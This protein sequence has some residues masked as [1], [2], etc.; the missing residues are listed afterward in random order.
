MANEAILCELDSARNA[1]E[2]TVSNGTAISKN[3]IL[4]LADP[5]TASASTGTGDIFGG[6]MAADKI[7]SDGATKASA[8]LEGKWKLVCNS[9]VAISTG[10]KVTS[11]GANLIRVA[12]AAEVDAGKWIGYAEE[13]I[14]VSTAGVVRL[15]GF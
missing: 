15:R 3:T 4:K 10:E 13:D 7:L 6:I 1:V 5:N 11:S 2:R 9:A 14:E 12:A 8:Y